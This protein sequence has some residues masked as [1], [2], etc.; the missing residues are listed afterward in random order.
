MSHSDFCHRRR[1]ASASGAIRG[2]AVAVLLATAPVSAQEQASLDDQKKQAEIDKL[3]AERDKIVAE[4]EKVAIDAMK[5]AATGIVGSGTVTGP[6]L[7]AEGLLLSHYLQEKA[8]AGIAARFATWRA[9]GNTSRTG[10]VVVAFGDQPPST[11]DYYALKGGIDRLCENLVLAVKQWNAANTGSPQVPVSD[12]LCGGEKMMAF[13]IVP[14]ITAV[15]TVASL[16]KVDTTVAGSAL[17]SPNEQFKAIL[18]RELRDRKLPL[19]P[20][21][22]IA[23][24]PEFA[25]TAL[26]RLDAAKEAAEPAY[27]AYLKA[28]KAA[29]DR[30]GK[31]EKERTIAGTSLG[32]ALADYDSLRKA[33]LTPVAGILPAHVVDQQALLAESRDTRPIIYIHHQKAALT[34]TTKK[35]LLTGIAGIP[36]FVSGSLVV[37][38]SFA[39]DQPGAGSLTVSSPTM[40]ITAVRPW[41]EGLEQPSQTR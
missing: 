7:S 26:K 21:L 25:S 19:D 3:E 20:P 27:E 10:P 31:P 38:F 36:A 17:A 6:E 35:G 24:E 5:G 11:A 37:D 34:T 4:R 28:L 33:L 16:L 32:T 12:S 2:L 41:L 13:P 22:T 15:T 39:G 14:V 30:G 9:A 29:T 40:R 1:S 8:A 18:L 23:G